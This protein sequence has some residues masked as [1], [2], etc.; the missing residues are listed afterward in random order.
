[1]LSVAL[2]AGVEMVQSFTPASLMEMGLLN[3]E[4]GCETCN[5]QHCDRDQML[6]G[7]N[8]HNRSEKHGNTL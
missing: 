6:N 1:M 4:G 3:S 7:T 2:E 5:R 8:R